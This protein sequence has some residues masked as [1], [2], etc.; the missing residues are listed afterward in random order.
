MKSFKYFSQILTFSLGRVIRTLNN[1]FSFHEKNTIFSENL[2]DVG[3]KKK[4]NTHKNERRENRKISSSSQFSSS[5][6]PETFRLICCR[7]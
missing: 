1:M 6:F 5:S 3:K 2:V 7:P 4:E